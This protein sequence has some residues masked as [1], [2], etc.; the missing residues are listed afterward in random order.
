MLPRPDCNF[1]YKRQPVDANSSPMR[2]NP[3]AT[4]MTKRN[5][6]RAGHGNLCQINNRMAAFARCNGSHAVCKSPMLRMISRVTLARFLANGADNARARRERCGGLLFANHRRWLGDDPPEGAYHTRMP[7]MVNSTGLR[8]SSAYSNRRRFCH[9]CSHRMQVLRLCDHRLAV[10]GH[11]RLPVDAL[12]L[13]DGWHPDAGVCR[14][15]CR[16]HRHN[17]FKHRLP[18]GRNRRI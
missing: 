2:L 12:R 14:R 10:P 9:D 1:S 6:L 4:A 15:R 17:R 16:F 5:F 18:A 7:Y 11:R 3:H 13:P 8:A